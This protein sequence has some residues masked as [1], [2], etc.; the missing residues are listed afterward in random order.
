MV[1]YGRDAV[2]S[3]AV[4]CELTGHVTVWRTGESFV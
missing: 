4:A 1:S 2:L 3:T